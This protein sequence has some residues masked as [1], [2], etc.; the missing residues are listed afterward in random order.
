MREMLVCSEF[1]Y[2]VDLVN[3]CL[4]FRYLLECMDLSFHEESLG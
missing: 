2:S 4:F 1:L 3:K